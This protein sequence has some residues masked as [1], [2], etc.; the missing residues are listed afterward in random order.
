MTEDTTFTWEIKLEDL[1]KFIGK[2]KSDG[3]MK[4]PTFFSGCNKNYKWHLS[5]GINDLFTSLYLCLDDSDI[6]NEIRVAYDFCLLYSDEKLHEVINCKSLF[7]VKT[8][9]EFGCKNFLHS[10][11]LYSYIF[12]LLL[13]HVPDNQDIHTVKIICR[14]QTEIISSIH[15]PIN[16]EQIPDF[17]KLLNN[18]KF[19]DFTVITSSGKQFKV[20]KNI[21]SARSAFFATMLASIMPEEEISAVKITD[22]DDQVIEELLRYIYCGK[23]KNIEN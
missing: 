19:S 18:P 7:H 11:V 17:E 2:N 21:L 12:G 4:S 20:H 6:P 15:N 13:I 10:K 22:F 3:N 1:F 23:V 5:L 16:I 9:P 8:K 14:M